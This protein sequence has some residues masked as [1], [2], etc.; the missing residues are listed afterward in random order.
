[1]LAGT[2]KGRVLGGCMTLVE[3]TIGTPWELDTND[4]ILVLE[5]RAMKP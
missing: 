5:D 3:T 1:M 2:A 4:A